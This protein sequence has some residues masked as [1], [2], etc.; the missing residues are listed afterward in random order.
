MN[1]KQKIDDMCWKA[2]RLGF[3]FSPDFTVIVENETYVPADAQ[4]PTCHVLETVL[5]GERQGTDKISDIAKLLEVSDDWVEAFLS[6][7]DISNRYR[8]EQSV[9]VKK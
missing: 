3:Q 4:N 2:L 1:P 6:G 5:L 9:V 8:V 7:Y